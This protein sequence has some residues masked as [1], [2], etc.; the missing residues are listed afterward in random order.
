ML[1][2]K[3]Y[4]AVFLGYWLFLALRRNIGNNESWKSILLSLVIIT[5]MNAPWLGLVWGWWP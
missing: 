1:L 4:S 2:L 5:A 3:V